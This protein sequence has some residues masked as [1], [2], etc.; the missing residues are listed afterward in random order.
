M[1]HKTLLFCLFKGFITETWEKRF[2]HRKE[3]SVGSGCTA[4][5]Q[6]HYTGKEWMDFLNNILNAV[7]R[8][9][10]P[11]SHAIQFTSH[12]LMLYLAFF[13]FS[14]CVTQSRVRSMD[15]VLV[16]WCMGAIFGLKNQA[17]GVRMEVFRVF[18]SSSAVKPD[19]PCLNE[20]LTHL[21]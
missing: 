9:I 1:K 17:G 21:K 2:L 13:I 20:T 10:V 18:H 19:F 5:K 7:V 12:C 3:W 15:C 8:C 6:R 11:L 4:E 16:W 14:L